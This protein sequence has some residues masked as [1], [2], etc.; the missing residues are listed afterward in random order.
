MTANLKQTIFDRVEAMKTK[1]LEEINSREDS[2]KLENTKYI[3]RRI[4]SNEFKFK[5][6]RSKKI[7]KEREVELKQEVNLT[8][9]E[10]LLKINGIIPIEK[11]EEAKRLMNVS[12]KNMYFFQIKKGEKNKILALYGEEFQSADSTVV[13][14]K[15]FIGNE[16]RIVSKE[17]IL[18]NPNLIAVST[19]NTTLPNLNL[20]ALKENEL[21][22]DSLFE[23]KTNSK[24]Q[25]NK[26]KR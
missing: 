26:L 12:T 20:K 23:V 5:L 22:I 10:K 19:A 17:D 2:L 9:K 8:L 13:L 25:N 16:T 24:N 4:I 6:E 11:I 21:T 18:S 14:L 3:R 1:S 7:L 15:S